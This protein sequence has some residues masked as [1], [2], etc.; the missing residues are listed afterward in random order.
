[1]WNFKTSE[2]DLVTGEKLQ[3]ALNSVADDY[4]LL[5][6]QMRL[7]DVYASH[8]TEAEKDENLKTAIDMAARIR[9]G[10]ETNLAVLQSV[11]TKLTGRCVPLLP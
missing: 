10:D 4:L 6:L 8:V 1:M 5:A 11:N 7:E 9:E 2:G 3:T